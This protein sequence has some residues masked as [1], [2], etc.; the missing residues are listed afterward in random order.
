M[1]STTQ[2]DEALQFLEFKPGC[3]LDPSLSLEIQLKLTPLQNSIT[4]IIPTITQNVSATE[5]VQRSYLI[6]LNMNSG[7]EKTL[8]GKLIETNGKEISNADR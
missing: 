3:I 5:T 2:V 4:S 6:K 1:G 7:I 8:R